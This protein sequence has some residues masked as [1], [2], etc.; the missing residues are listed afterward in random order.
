[1]SATIL[2][3]D[4]DQR[5]AL[6]VVRSL[7]RVGHRVIVTAHRKRSLAGASR[8]AAAGEQV[9]DPG[10]RPHA[11]GDA[12]VSLARRYRADVVIPITEMSTLALLPVRPALRPACLSLADGH[13]F[14]HLCDK[15]HVME[16]AAEIGLAVPPQRIVHDP[17]GIGD[18]TLYP[19]VIK[20]SRSVIPAASGFAK[21]RVAYA[22]DRAQLIEKLQ[23]LPPSMFPVLVQKRVQGPGIGLFLLLWEGR[24]VASFS[25]RRLREKPPS[26]GVS[27][28]R[29]SIAVDPQLANLSRTLLEK[30]GWQGVAM[31]EFKLDEGTGIPYLMEV[32]PRFWGSLQLAVDAGVDFP[33][34]LLSVVR[35]QLPAPTKPYRLGIRS[36][37]WWGDVDAL[38]MQLCKP[39]A[40]LDLPAHAPSRLRVLRDFLVLW[41]PTDRNEVFHLRD[42]APAIRETLDWFRALLFA[43]R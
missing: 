23:R 16:L 43:E 30:C 11:Y 28:Y 3:T 18:W 25:H 2:V 1:M 26:G 7:G 39:R 13:A 32:N 6:A 4:G 5:A 24:L 21:T 29:E 31:V 36:R 15:A 34:L 42:P 12:V 10:T 8:Y 27:V 14:N 20:P 33:A 35:G 41:R 19:A 37:W 40:S 17:G 22:Q 38:L 9:P